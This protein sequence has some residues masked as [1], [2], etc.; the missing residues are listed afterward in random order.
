[1]TLLSNVFRSD[2]PTIDSF[3]KKKIEIRPVVVEE[4]P[5]QQEISVDII[6]AEKERRLQ[7]FERQLED[8]RNEIEQIRQTALDDIAVM[9]SVWQKEKEQLQ[10]QVYDEAFQAG[11]EEGRNKALAEM[12]SAVRL[13]NETT[14]QSYENAN[15]YLNAQEKVILEIALRTAERIIGEVL[16][17]DDHYYLSFIQRGLK[18]AREM[19]EIKLY[20]PLERFKLVSD[21]RDELASLF[22]PD[23]PFLIFVHEEFEKNESYIETNHGRIVV[24]VDDQLTEVKNRLIELLEKGD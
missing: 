1:M 12:E 15:K 24:T 14:K 23:V 5:V 20:V 7:Q 19:K 21:H 17:N 10:Q 9:Q 2:Y 3:P 22:P 8:E 11:F 6:F 4:E 18:E 13:A 16:N